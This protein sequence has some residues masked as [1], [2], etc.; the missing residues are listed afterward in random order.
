MADQED[1]I[2]KA[3]ERRLA[4]ERTKQARISGESSPWP[5]PGKRTEQQQVEVEAYEVAVAWLKEKWG[6]EPGCPYCGNNEWSV[7]V[8][9]Q[10]TTRP[11]MA[12]APTFGSLP[13]VFPV[14]CTNC[15]QTTFVSAI[16]AGIVPQPGEE[17]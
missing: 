5:P 11:R 1:I 3:A 16:L 9:T 10:L 7:G 14:M 12:P 4:V 2:R 6:D 8:P 13:A 17:S 15:G